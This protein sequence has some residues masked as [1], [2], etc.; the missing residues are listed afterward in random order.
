MNTQQVPI[1]HRES[2]KRERLEARISPRL[3]SLLQHAAEL[4]G[5]SLTDFV[6]R[7]AEEAAKEVVRD[8]MVITLSAEDSRVFAEAILNPPKP[9]KKLRAEY[10]RYK[11]MVS[12]DV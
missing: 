4:Q 3:K 2:G 6:V 7:S 12:S 10:A 11:R 1:N 5:R 9:N 8:H